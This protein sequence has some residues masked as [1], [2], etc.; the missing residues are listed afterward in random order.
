M[1]PKD[2]KAIVNTGKGKGRS[3]KIRSDDSDN[4][5]MKSKSPDDSLWVRKEFFKPG[6]KTKK[7]SP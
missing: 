2:S 6:K 7:N 1:L 3:F 5:I 4:K